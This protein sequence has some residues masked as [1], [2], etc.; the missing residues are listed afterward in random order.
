MASCVC[1]A[2][3]HWQL[4][5]ATHRF[6]ADGM[7]LERLGRQGQMPRVGRMGLGLFF[8]MPSLPSSSVSSSY[9]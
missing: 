6:G 2:R 7:E 4:R 1:R 9:G 3:V 5:D 8:H